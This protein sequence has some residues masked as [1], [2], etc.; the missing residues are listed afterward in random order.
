MKKEKMGLGT[1]LKEVEKRIGGLSKEEIKNI[2]LIKIKR[3]E[4]C[5]N[6]IG[7]PDNQD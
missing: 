5:Y 6:E 1:F 3:S 4:Q 2:F 7:A